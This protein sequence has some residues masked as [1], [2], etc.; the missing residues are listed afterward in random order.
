MCQ[1][2]NYLKD[3]D[4]IWYQGSKLKDS[5]LQLS[6]EVHKRFWPDTGADEENTNAML[7]P[8]VVLYT[9]CPFTESTTPLLHNNVSIIVFQN[10]GFRQT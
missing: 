7:I 10:G 9:S 4:E 2:E 8:F 6:V 5:G 1:T 3:L